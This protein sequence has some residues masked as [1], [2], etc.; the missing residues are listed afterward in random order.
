MSRE[1]LGVQSSIPWFDD[2]DFD[3]AVAFYGEMLG[4][5]QVLDQGWARVFRIAKDASVGLVNTRAGNGSCRPQQANA[6]LLTLVV[7]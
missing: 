6:V 1:R 7:G 5:E 2:Q 4:L 3:A